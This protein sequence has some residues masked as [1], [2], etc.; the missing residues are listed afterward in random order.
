MRKEVKAFF[1]N[2]KEIEFVFQPSSIAVH[3]ITSEI[4]ILSA[5]DRIVSIYNKEGLKKCYL[6][7]AE[8]Y[9]KPEGLAFF[10]NGDLIISNEGSKNG[11]V[12]GNLVFLNYKSKL[13]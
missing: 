13:K 4:Y 8:I 5:D 1:P 10:E 9:Y 6:L 3:P 11:L 7:P 2:Q 12:K